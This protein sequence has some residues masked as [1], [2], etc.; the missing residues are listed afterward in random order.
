MKKF[1][2]EG[3]PLILAMVM[4][5]MM[6]EAMRQSLILSAGSATIFFTP[7]DLGWIHSYRRVSLLLPSPH[8][9]KRGGKG[10]GKRF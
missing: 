4:G 9:E 5:P 2:Y 7:T 10:L 3:A 6:E 1:D 8:P